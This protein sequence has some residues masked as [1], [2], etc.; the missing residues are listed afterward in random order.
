MHT[1]DIGKFIF[2]PVLYTWTVKYW[3]QYTTSHVATTARFSPKITLEAISVHLNSKTFPGEHAPPQR[4]QR[5]SQK[6]IKLK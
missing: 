5:I 3:M 6:S 2:G 1:G 4:M